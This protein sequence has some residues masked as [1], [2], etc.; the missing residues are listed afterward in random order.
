[1]RAFS[2]LDNKVL[3]GRIVYVKPAL[4]DIGKIISTGKEI[5]Y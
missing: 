1:M 2:E 4:Q 5:A 3:F